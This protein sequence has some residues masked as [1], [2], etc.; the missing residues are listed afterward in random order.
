MVRCSSART[1]KHKLE[2][3]Q[4]GGHGPFMRRT[5]VAGGGRARREAYGPKP[6]GVSQRDEYPD[7]T[8]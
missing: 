6:W 8:G 3:G 7:C 5:S 2:E 1:W 4:G